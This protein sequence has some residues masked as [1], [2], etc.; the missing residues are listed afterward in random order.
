MAGLITYIIISDYVWAGIAP[1][2]WAGWS[3]LNGHVG[4]VM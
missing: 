4:T 1:K 3:G 2:G